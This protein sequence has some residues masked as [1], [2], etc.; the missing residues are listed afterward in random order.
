M[1]SSLAARPNLFPANGKAFHSASAQGQARKPLRR[2]SPRWRL[3][4]ISRCTWAHR[5]SRPSTA[6]TN[7]AQF[8]S[9]GMTDSGTDT[10]PT[11]RHQILCA[12]K[13]HMTLCLPSSPQRARRRPAAPATPAD[14]TSAQ[15]AAPA[16]KRT[17]A[18]SRKGSGCGRFAGER[19]SQL[20]AAAA[21]RSQCAS[22]SLRRSPLQMNCVS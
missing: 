6:A 14:R 4:L 9:Q 20:L 22:Q 16:V 15:R 19:V 2:T 1:T 17:L 12:E 18:A 21:S 13:K 5:H 7:H 11:T 10:C 8:S 3:G